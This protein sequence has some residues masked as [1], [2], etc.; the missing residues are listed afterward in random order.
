[1]ENRYISQKLERQSPFAFHFAAAGDIIKL[2]QWAHKL[3]I[4]NLIWRENLRV[5]RGGNLVQIL[6][7]EIV[8]KCTVLE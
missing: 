4:H 5:L 8:Q 3:R 2:K 1:M 7:M 6:I